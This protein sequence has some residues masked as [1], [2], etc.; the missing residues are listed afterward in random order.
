MTDV[1]VQHLSLETGARIQCR[2]CVRQIAIY[3]DKLAVSIIVIIISSI[4]IFYIL[5]VKPKKS[6][7]SPNGR[8]DP[9]QTDNLLRERQT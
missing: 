7:D 4:R 5:P 8:A 2:D 6:S 1:Y 9:L 3:G